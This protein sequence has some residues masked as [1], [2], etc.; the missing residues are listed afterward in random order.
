MTWHQSIFALN[1]I[2]TKYTILVCRHF[3]RGL[4]QGPTRLIPFVQ[5]VSEMKANNNIILSNNSH[6]GWQSQGLS[7]N[8]SES[9]PNKCH[10]IVGQNWSCNLRGDHRTT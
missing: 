6:L 5:V 7:W 10:K 2:L 3:E 9:G 8:N 1:Y 4:T